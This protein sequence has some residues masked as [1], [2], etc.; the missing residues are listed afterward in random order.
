MGTIVLYH[1]FQS[2]R[3]QQVKHVLKYKPNIY[4]YRSC[5]KLISQNINIELAKFVYIA[6]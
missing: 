2:Y 3:L 4:S 5:N 6:S 1:A